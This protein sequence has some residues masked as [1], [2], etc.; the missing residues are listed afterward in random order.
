VRGNRWSEVGWRSG[1]GQES[2]QKCTWALRLG[3][4][5]LGGFYMTLICNLMLHISGS[6]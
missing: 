6:K 5:E 3:T 2:S 1:T 4:Q